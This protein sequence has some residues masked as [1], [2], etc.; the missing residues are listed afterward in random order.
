MTGG[1]GWPTGAWLAMSFVVNVEEG[2]EMSPTE[3]DRGPEA[4]N[5]LA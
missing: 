3:G 1:F 2:S 5:E 4:V